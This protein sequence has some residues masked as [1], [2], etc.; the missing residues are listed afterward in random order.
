M[1]FKIGNHIT[2]KQYD[3]LQYR[4]VHGTHNRI[5]EGLANKCSVEETNLDG[6][7]IKIRFH[8]FG[9]IHR[10]TDTIW[11]HTKEFELFHVKSL[12]ELVTPAPIG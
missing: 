6:D 3:L 9:D 8:D 12:N 10:N 2:L 7:M 1:S 5:V 4:K 11:L